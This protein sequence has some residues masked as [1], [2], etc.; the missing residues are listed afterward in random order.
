MHAIKR[1][2]RSPRPRA[3]SG[4]WRV[5]CYA[6]ATACRDSD[7]ARR[8]RFRKCTGNFDAQGL[9]PIRPRSAAGARPV[10]TTEARAYLCCS[11]QQLTCRR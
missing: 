9:M 11:T 10:P 8:P 2:L 7:A 1:R 6:L 3:P 4:L 5:S